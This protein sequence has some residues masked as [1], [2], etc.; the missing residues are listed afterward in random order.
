MQCKVRRAYLALHMQMD[1]QSFS[2][3]QHW[4]GWKEKLK[5][6]YKDRYRSGY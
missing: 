6:C 2:L 5:G 4:H 1:L 3:L